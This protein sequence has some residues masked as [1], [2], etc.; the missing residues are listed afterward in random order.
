MTNKERFM[1]ALSGAQP[2]SVPVWEMGINEVGIIGIAKHFTENVPEVKLIHEMNLQEQMQLLMAYKVLAEELDLDGFTMPTLTGREDLGNN[3]VK[4]KLQIVTKITPHGEPFP[5][6]GPIR[7]PSDIKTYKMP[8]PDESFLTAVQFAVANFKDKKAI[9]LHSPGTFKLSWCLRGKME[10]LLIDYIENP[11]FACELA[12]MVTDFC[13]QLFSMAFDAGVDAIILEGDLAM[14]TN[15][16]MSPAHYREFIKP[17]HAQIIET[18]HKKGGKIAKHSDGNLWPILDDLIEVGFDG[19]HPI[20]PQCMNIKEVK[21]HCGDKVCLM[22]NIDCVDILPNGTID[23]VEKAVKETIEIAAPGGGYILSSSNSIHPGCKVENYIA[24]V[25][26]AKKYGKYS[27]S[28]S[29]KNVMKP[30]VNTD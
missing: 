21:E 30:Q 16:I 19:I 7:E 14:N 17:Y 24:M 8:K 26:F 20:Q 6:E 29:V 5:V 28:G 12:Q 1:T 3:L 11:K 9:V 15:T 2:D 22:G 25:R 10:K 4:D 13:C 18:V 23:D 27:D